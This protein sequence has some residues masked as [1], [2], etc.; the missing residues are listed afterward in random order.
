MTEDQKKTINL[1]FPLSN[2]KASLD[3]ETRGVGVLTEIHV[4][5]HLGTFAIVAIACH[6]FV[7]GQLALA[8]ADAGNQILLSATHN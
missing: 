2:S 3:R 5:L 8:R 7:G 6:R 4:A 1:G